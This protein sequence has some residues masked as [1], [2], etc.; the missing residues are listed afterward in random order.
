MSR[1][2]A[3]GSTRRW[4]RIRREVLDRDGWR[5]RLAIP[6]TWVTR[7]GKTQACLVAAD[8]VHHTRGKAHGDDPRHLIAACT[9]CNLKVGDPAATP[10][11]APRPRTDW[12]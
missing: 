7:D 8:C 1:G 9:P 5:C 4:R 3:G 12:S 6:G 10:D 11:P 2:W